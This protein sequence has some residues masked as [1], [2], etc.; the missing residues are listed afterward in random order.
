[1]DKL[2]DIYVNEFKQENYVP[3][4]DEDEFE[5][6]KESLINAILNVKYP[7]TAD[8]ILERLKICHNNGYLG[9]HFIDGKHSSNVLSKYLSDLFETDYCINT[10]YCSKHNKMSIYIN[11]TEF[12][13]KGECNYSYINKYGAHIA[14]YCYDLN[15]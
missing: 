15:E 14:D 8:N 1:M 11:Y 4:N 5:K 7:I 13:L 2:I 9:F 3:K 10:I 6:Q 12:P